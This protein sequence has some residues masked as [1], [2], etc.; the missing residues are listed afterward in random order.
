MILCIVCLT[1]EIFL[2]PHKILVIVM[3][4]E[5]YEI[6]SKKD[7]K[8]SRLRRLQ[9]LRIIILLPAVILII[10]G[11]STGNLLVTASAVALT[12][13]IAYPFKIKIEKEFKVKDE[14]GY[15]IGEKAA[16][17]TLII[18]TLAAI[19]LGIALDTVTKQ[20][21]QYTTIGI[22][23]NISGFVIIILYASFYAYYKRKYS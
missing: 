21:P 22:T 13:I 17:Q 23:L 7:D 15:Y 6:E 1:L 12:F 2:S 9:V 3:K 16:R 18:F 20:Y 10:Y 5:K 19:Y 11:I 14:R 8:N 4:D